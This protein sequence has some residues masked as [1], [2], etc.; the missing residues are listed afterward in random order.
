M[1]TCNIEYA[2]GSLY[3][4]LSI[5][6]ICADAGITRMTWYNTI[7]CH[8]VPSIETCFRIRDALILF[9]ESVRAPE[10]SRR[11]MDKQRFL[12]EYAFVDKLWSMRY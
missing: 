10:G 8:K 4:D 12:R 11:W 5:S 9:A 7:K 1:I 2:L 3:R 6:E